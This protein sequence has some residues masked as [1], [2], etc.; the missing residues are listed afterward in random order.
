MDLPTS[1]PRSH[2]VVRGQQAYQLLSFQG[3]FPVREDLS[4]VTDEDTG[5]AQPPPPSKFPVP[6]FRLKN[7]SDLFGLG[8]EELGP[9]ESS[10]E[11]RRAW[12]CPSPWNLLGLGGLVCGAPMFRI[13]TAYGF[14]FVIVISCER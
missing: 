9:K 2:V 6:A 4:D 7:D 8:L 3:R 1:L 11:G 10:E 12:V 13:Y 5:P 14:S